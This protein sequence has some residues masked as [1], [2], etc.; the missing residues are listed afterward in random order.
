M[1][2]SQRCNL[3]KVLFKLLNDIAVHMSAE[4]RFKTVFSNRAWTFMSIWVI[5]FVSW[6]KTTQWNFWWQKWIIIY[7]F[8]WF[9]WTLRWVLRQWKTVI[10]QLR[11]LE[12]EV[13]NGIMLWFYIMFKSMLI[14]MYMIWGNKQCISTTP[15]RFII[16]RKLLVHQE[17]L[18]KHN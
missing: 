12:I 11:M 14:M 4:D 8:M 15:T 1:V 7:V 10:I 16:N 17:D 13:S 18:Y 6:T 9:L 5:H 2:L 3:C